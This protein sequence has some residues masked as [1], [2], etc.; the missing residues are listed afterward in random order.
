[1][2]LPA[3]GLSTPELEIW[4]IRATAQNTLVTNH[5]GDSNSSDPSSIQIPSDTKHCNFYQTAWTLDLCFEAQ[6]LDLGGES[7]IYF[8]LRVPDRLSV[9]CVEDLEV[10]FDQ[11]F[12]IR[13]ISCPPSI[14]FSTRLFAMHSLSLFSVFLHRQPYWRPPF[15]TKAFQVSGRGYSGFRKPCHTT[16]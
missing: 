6:A 16:D 12:E 9:F 7:L 3:R 13:I 10:Y 8:S 15:A 5:F 1:M 14:N 4:H 2:D 11:M